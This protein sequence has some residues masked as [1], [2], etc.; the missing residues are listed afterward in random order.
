MGIKQNGELYKGSSAYSLEELEL[1]V[2]YVKGLIQALAEAIR[3]E[4]STL[5]PIGRPLPEPAGT[6]RTQRCAVLSWGVP[7]CRY[8][9]ITE[10]GDDEV[11][12]M[13]KGAAAEEA[14][15]TDEVEKGGGL[16]GG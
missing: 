5:S 3:G 12:K 15:G 4:E 1:L 16:A 7:G 13:I 9:Y 11:L 10:I 2:T 6:A 8:R 14:S